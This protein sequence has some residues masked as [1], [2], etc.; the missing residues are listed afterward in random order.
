MKLLRQILGT[1]CT[2]IVILSPFALG[3]LIVY[4]LAHFIQ[5][6]W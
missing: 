1:I 3:G 5:K 2:I 4:V 6:Y